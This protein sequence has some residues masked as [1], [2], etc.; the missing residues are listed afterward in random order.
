M[1]DLGYEPRLFESNKPTHYILDHGDF[2]K[3]NYLPIMS[4]EILFQ[5]LIN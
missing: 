2:M 1:T 4:I 5:A 3:S